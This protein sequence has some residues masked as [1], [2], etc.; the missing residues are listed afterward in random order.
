MSND[1][2]IKSHDLNSESQ[3]TDL[4]GMNRPA[5]SFSWVVLWAI[6]PHHVQWPPEREAAIIGGD[7]L[8]RAS[9]H[10]GRRTI[11]VYG[12]AGRL[13]GPIRGLHMHG[14]NWKLVW[15]QLSENKT[16]QRKK[17]SC[18][19]LEQWYWMPQRLTGIV[20]ASNDCRNWGGLAKCVLHVIVGTEDGFNTE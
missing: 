4:G 2:A 7:R 15:E 20:C 1:F 16:R 13:L 12:D 18:G 9:V 8:I 19:G 17:G 6:C 3:K 11:A 10:G 14:Q 5:R